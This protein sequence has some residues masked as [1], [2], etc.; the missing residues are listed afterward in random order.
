MFKNDLIIAICFLI[1]GGGSYL[2]FLKDVKNPLYHRGDGPTPSNYYGMW[3]AV[4]M[5]I[6]MFIVYLFRW[7]QI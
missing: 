7:L 3:G 4:I 5:A 2:L 1:G 6:L